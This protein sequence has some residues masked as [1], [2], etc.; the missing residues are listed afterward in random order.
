MVILTLTLTLLTLDTYLRN[1]VTIFSN[2]LIIIVVL[3][4]IF[5]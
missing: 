1:V 4:T 3:E 2:T 5:E